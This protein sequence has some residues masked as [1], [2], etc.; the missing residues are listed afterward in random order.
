MLKKPSPLKHKEEGH[1]LLDEEAH[2]EAHGGEVES[3]DKKED[4]KEDIIKKILPN[5]FETKEE[6]NTAFNIQVNSTKTDGAKNNVDVKNSNEW[7]LATEDEVQQLN[8]VQDSNNDGIPDSID[9]AYWDKRI[10]GAKNNYQLQKIYNERQKAQGKKW[11][12]DK[13]GDHWKGKE[14]SDYIRKKGAWYY[15]KDGKEEKVDTSEKAD[16]NTKAILKDLNKSLYTGKFDINDPVSWLSRNEKKVAAELTQADKFPGIIARDLGGFDPHVYVELPNGERLF[17]DPNKHEDALKKYRKITSFYKNNDKDKDLLTALQFNDFKEFNANWAKVGYKM[18]PMPDGTIKLQDLDGKDI[19]QGSQGDIR[20]YLY[21]NASKKDIIKIKDQAKQDATKL[22]QETNDKREELSIS[23]IDASNKYIKEKF[24]DEVLFTLNEN[25]ISQATIDAIE[26]HINSTQLKLQGLEDRKMESIRNLTYRD[27]ESNFKSDEKELQNQLTDLSSIIAKI[28]SENP[29]HP[30]LA[31]LENILPQID[32][33]IKTG[34]KGAKNEIL[35]NTL[36]AWQSKKY[37]ESNEH[38]IKVGSEYLKRESLEKKEVVKKEIDDEV[39]N[40]MQNYEKTL[41]DFQIIFTDLAKDAKADGVNVKLDESNNFIVTGDDPEKVAFYKKAFSTQNLVL[42]THKEDLQLANKN[43]NKR[44]LDWQNDHADILKLEDQSAREHDLWKINS[45]K[46]ED[47]F[48]SMANSA[49]SLFGSENREKAIQNTKSRREGA[50]DGLEIALDYQTALQTGQ[51]WRYS[52]GEFATQ[53]ANILM[54]TV[55]SGVGSAFGLSS[56]AIQG[57]ISYGLFGTFSGTQKYMDLT[58]SQQAAAEAKI[59]LDKLIKEK[60]NYTPQDFMRTK[61]E[62]EKTIAY[63][64]ISEKDKLKLSFASAAVEGTI[65]TFIGT[66]ANSLNLIRKIK[67]PKLGI[68]NKLLRS[69][70]K[71]VGDVAWQ[72]TKGILGEIV[73]ETSIEALNIVND[74]LVLGRDY[75]FSQLDD[76]AITSIITSGGMTTLPNTYAAIV[77]QSQTSEY[78]TEIN[79]SLNKLKEIEAKFVTLDLND[80]MRDVYVDEYRSEIEKIAGEHTKL[81]VDALAMDSKNMQKLLK[82][83]VEENYLNQQADV[84]PSDNRKTIEQRRKNHLESL[85]TE[86]QKNYKDRIQAIDNQRKKLVENINYDDAAVKIFGERGK[87]WEK[88]LKDNSEYKKADKREKLALILKKVRETHVKDATK[89]AKRDKW[90]QNRVEKQV[91]GMPFD[92]TGRKNRK[93]KEESALYQDWGSLLL[94]NQRQALMLAS[95][96][97]TSLANLRTKQEIANLKIRETKSKDELYEAVYSN[98]KLSEMEKEGIVTAIKSGEAKAVLI[99]NEYLVTNEEAARKNLEKGD[100]L[101]GTAIA[102]EISHFI[103]NTSFKNAEEQA[104]YTHNL[105]KLIGDVAPEAHDRAIM[106]VNNI[107]DAEGNLLYDET[108]SFEEQDI[109]YKD[110]YTKAVQD[111]L[112]DP[113]WAKEYDT[114]KKASGQGVANIIRGVVKGDFNINTPANAGAWMVEY[115]NNFKKGEISPLA[116]RKIK[117]AQEA[118]VSVARPGAVMSADNAKQNLSVVQNDATDA[119]GNFIPE[120]YNPDSATILS[121]LPGMIDAQVNNYFARRPSLKVDKPARAELAQEIY[122]RLYTPSKT[123]RSDVNGFDGTGT[124]YGYLNGRIKYRMLDTFEQNPTIVPDYTQKEIDDARTDLRKELADDLTKVQDEALDR[125]KNKINVLKIG[126]VVDKESAIRDVVNVKE[127]DT[128]KEVTDKFTG[129]VAEIIFDVPA[130]KI[131]DPTKNLTYAKK[132]IDGIPE[133]SEAGNIQNFYATGDALSKLIRILPEYNVSSEDADI[134]ELGENIDVSPTVKG[135]SLGL[136]NKILQYFYDPVIEDGKHKRSTGKTSQVKLYKLKDKFRNPSSEAI[137]KVKEEAGIT[138]RGELNNYDRGIGQFLKG[139]GFFQGQQTALS[140]AQRNLSELAVEKQRIA[141][142]TA[143]QSKYAFSKADNEIAKEYKQGK[144]YYDINSPETVERYIDEDV[145]R[146][147]KVFEEYPGLI[148]GNELVNGLNAIRDPELKKALRAGVKGITKKG[149]F[150]KRDFAKFVGNTVEQ[151]KNEAKINEFNKQAGINFEA[152]WTAID[153]AL[154]N[155]PTLLG[156]LLIYLSN[157]V[158]SKTHVHRSGAKFIAYDKTVEGKLYLEHA[159]QNVNA[160]RTLIRASMNDKSKDRSGFKKAFKALKTNYNLIGV[161]GIDNT[162]LDNGIY[163]DE[164][165]KTVSFKNGMGMIDGKAWNIFEHK[166][167]QRY[168]NKI[169]SKLGGINPEN[170]TVVGSKNNLAQE[171]DINPEGDASFVI[172]SGNNPV[173]SEATSNSRKINKDTES[174][175]MSAFDFDETLIDKGD[176]TIIA[177]K[178]DETIEITSSQWPIDGPTLA[179]QGYKFNFDDFINVRGGV[180]GPLMKKFKNRIKKYGIENN[181]I[182]TARP[183]E[184]APAIQAWLKQ[185]GINMPLKNITGLGNSTGEAKAMWMAQ[186]YAEG[187]NDMYFVD[188]ALPNV[189]AVK[190]MMNQLDIK[191]SSVQAKINFSKGM[192][193]TFNKIIEDQSGIDA[194]K[195]FSKTKA[196]IRGKNKGKYKFFIPSSAEDFNGLLYTLLPKGKKGEQAYSF[197]KE[198]LLDPYARGYREL[199]A[200]KQTVGNDYKALRKAMPDTRK[201]LTKKI[202]NLKDF[203]FSDAVRV[204]LWDKAGFEIPGLSKTDKARLTNI[205][206]KDEQLTKYA[207]ALGLISKRPEGYV[208]PRRDWLVTNI[209]G[210]LNDAMDKVGRKEFLAEWK[211]NKDIIFSPEN[212]NKLEAIHGSR[213]VE[214]LKDMLYRMET[215]TN[216]TQGD[217]RLVNGFMNWTNNSVG[218]IMFFNARSAVLQTLSSVNFINWKDNNILEAGKAFANQP[219]FWK[220][221]STLFN[222]DMLKQRRKGLK[223][224]VNHAELTEAV[225]RSKNPAMAALNYLLQKGFLPTQIADSFAIASGGATFYRNR[226]KTHLKQGLTQEQAETKAFEDF[227]ETAE[228]TQQS[229]RPDFISQQ[230]ASPLG[231]LI[232]AFQNTP[233]Q[234]MRLTKRAMQDLAAGRGDAKTHISRIL[235]YGAIQNLIFA[236][237]Q[238]ALFALAFDDEEDDKELN[239]K[240]ENKKKRILNT[241]LDSMLRGMGVGG[242]IVSTVKNMIKK[243]AEEQEKGWDKDLDAVWVEGL[244]L[245]PPIGS[246]IRKLRSAGKSWDYNEEIIPEMKT[247]SINNPIW[248]AVG[249]VVSATTNVP[250][251]RVVNKTRNIKEALNDQNEAW[252]RVA[253]ALGWN[254]WDLDIEKPEEIEEAREIVKEKK[255]IE[256]EQKKLIKEEEKINKAI[257]IQEQQKKKGEQVTCL[258]CKNP[259][260]AGQRY[261]TVH[262]EVKERKDKKETVCTFVKPNGQRCKMLTKA[263]SGLCY[264]HD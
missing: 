193:N 56:L 157:A 251:D 48:Y 169:I 248:S 22:I 64:N 112:M 99:D 101:Q 239:A 109:M 113:R 214:A 263:K 61:M 87:Y 75:D 245:S 139:L 110:E 179:A 208:K 216:R 213:Y 98:D 205:V 66:A 89:V 262:E 200:A 24:K 234:Y 224:D 33:N 184:S 32:K 186:K 165:N 11:V 123:G 243:F 189:E 55:S 141:D 210:D 149:D 206:K 73:E 118:G 34:L 93:T 144:T 136:K 230:Q 80:P 102:H 42:R 108:K 4:K 196:E 82:L 167:W 26:N 232:L 231:R 79:K 16:K 28:K 140:A 241:M 41:A 146:I 94:V 121:E 92:E 83:S 242:A 9:N 100:L 151:M 188:D 46:F 14:E 37:R 181:Y 25:N 65:G 192:D 207:D 202:P 148:S 96:G 52:T 177:T 212:L 76:V 6:K 225:G 254:T 51:L 104:N 154:Y 122:G 182:L 187:Y 176:N 2:K 170:F 120:R 67:T 49:L 17:I 237:L 45:S 54:A 36:T 201:K 138:P 264:Y 21:E 88:K 147:V 166:W 173:I 153:K 60:D 204:Y 150:P 30:D 175:G 126:K 132:I 229:S 137:Q 106:R 29:D 156:P 183:A 249:N 8:P 43:L 35:D 261:C 164:N 125:P 257:E 198:A 256:K 258:K 233:M 1:L 38:S 135:R 78:R 220:D 115:I 226:T 72:S 246:K 23:N 71:A 85:S 260:V 111:I 3:K 238:S 18:L 244:Q 223:T 19:T 127:G 44:Y 178:G 145:P 129:S 171:L 236:S 103:D 161:S 47:G 97:N 203:H 58:I 218:A 152:H 15:V 255:K 27:K 77:Q 191:G 69:N 160:Y 142:I 211:Q 39:S 12:V 172:P 217:N 50:Q 114:V 105:N 162:K 86:E 199:N 117:A 197:F 31:I 130:K 190:D 119:D 40:L 10:K 252:Q 215:G 180:E 5:L 158:N 228:A 7:R 57:G 107:T 185:Q 253:L 240:A 209:L 81:E 74:G 219:Q 133:A 155:D 134:N 84:K 143:A 95:E 221:F 20:K 247:F 195:V 53:S 13:R 68:S 163:V 70:L 159:L 91:Y 128:H 174:R 116:K 131:T 194:K 124:L 62:L 250:M 59:R 90:V 222:S 168:F 259:V 63:G 235:Y 227:Q